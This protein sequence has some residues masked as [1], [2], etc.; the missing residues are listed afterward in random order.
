MARYK[1]RQWVP[2]IRG[3]HCPRSFRVPKLIRKL[4][5]SARLPERDTEQSLPNLLLKWRTSHIERHCES[6]SLAGKVL[7]QFFLR[8]NQY[9]MFGVLDKFRETN[10]SWIVVLPKDSDQAFVTRDQFKPSDGRSN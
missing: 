2:A 4:P 8:A 1:D 9:R 3:A 5:I 7:I 10:T 6:I